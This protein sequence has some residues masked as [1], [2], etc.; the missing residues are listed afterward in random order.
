VGELI[1]IIVPV[2]NVEQYLDRCIESIVNQTYSNLEIILVNDGSTDGSSEICSKYQ[3][4]DDRIIVINKNNSGLSSARNAGLNIAK[5][6]YVGFVD[7]D[8]YISEV[9]YENLYGLIKQT[10]SNIAIGGRYR[11]YDNSCEIEQFRNYPSP[12]MTNVEALAALMSYRGF[13]MSVCDKIFERKLFDDIEFPLGKTCED[14]FVTY[15]IFSRVNKVAYDKTPYYYYYQRQNSISRN[16]NVNETV[17]EASYEQLQFIS[18]NYSTLSNEAYTSYIIS[19]IAIY[20][21]YIIRNKKWNDAKK[22][23]KYAL[24][25]IHYVINNKHI[26]KTKKMQIVIFAS[27]ISLYKLLYKLIKK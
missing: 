10:K 26:T 13:D 23:Q 17:L 5:G 24:E 14:S 15:K 7:G 18:A 27:S 9:M 8:D 12:V 20:N 19:S 11:A 16:L 3:K 2:Y 1:T 6:K 22:Y 25:N 21:E 4:S